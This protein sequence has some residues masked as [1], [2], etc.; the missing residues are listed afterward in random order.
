MVTRNLTT[1]KEVVGT[2]VFTTNMKLT[3]NNVEVIIEAG[4]KKWKIENG[5]NNILKNNGYNL[6]HNYGQGK[7]NL[8]EVIV[9]LM[10]IVFF[11]SHY[12]FL[13]QSGGF[14]LC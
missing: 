9:M 4:K 5:G 3:D 14:C 7:K 10:M 1:G 11:I 8:S 12:P 13:C 2:R 6:K